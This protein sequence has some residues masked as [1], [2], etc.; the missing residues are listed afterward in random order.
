MSLTAVYRFI[1]RVSTVV[2]TV[3]VEK[4][5]GDAAACVVTFE[6]VITA[7]YTL[8][9]ITLTKPCKYVGFSNRHYCDFRVL[10]ASVL[11]KVCTSVQAIAK[12]ISRNF[13]ETYNVLI[14]SMTIM[15][16]HVAL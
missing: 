2:S 4:F 13:D 9:T 8:I 3:T 11:N 10:L 5:C 7:S 12:P 15:Q 14:T 1:R 6:L 16:I